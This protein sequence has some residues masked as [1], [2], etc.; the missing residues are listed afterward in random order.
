MRNRRDWIAV[1]AVLGIVTAVVPLALSY[2]SRVEMLTDTGETRAAVESSLGR[3]LPPTAGSARDPRLVA[4][5]Q[6]LQEERYVASVWLVDTSGTIA[7]HLGGPGRA[8]QNV[9]TLADRDID[10]VLESLPPQ[11]FSDLQKLQLLTVAA[12]RSEGEHNDVFRHLVRPVHREDGSLAA[13]VAVAYDVS[14]LVGSVSFRDVFVTIAFF[15]GLAS[16]WLGLPLWVW[17]DAASRGESAIL[18]GVFVLITNLVGLVAY[19]IVVSRPRSA[20]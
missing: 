19:L 4:A 8:G 14:P 10:R 16:Y 5:A 6:R 3:L 15:V 12:V 11:T 13:L 18:W 7:V 1:A 17:L 9:A 20:A 2:P